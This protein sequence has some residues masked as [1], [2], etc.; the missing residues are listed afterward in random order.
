[1]MSLLLCERLN[2][3]KRPRGTGSRCS[4]GM[5]EFHGRPPDD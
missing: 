4:R 3:K 1:M 2:I 5:K